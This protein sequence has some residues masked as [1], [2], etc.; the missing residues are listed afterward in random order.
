MLKR[1]LTIFPLFLIT[2]SLHAQQTIGLLQNSPGNL[3]GYILFTPN[4]SDTTYLIDKCGYRIHTWPSSHSPALSVYLMDDGSI[5][6]PGKTNN[7]TFNGGGQGGI[8][9]RI[10]WNGNVVWSYTISS[11]TECQHHD[12]FPMANGNI[13]VIAYDLKTPADLVGAGR[14][15]THIGTSLWSEKILELQPVGSSGANIV[16]QWNLWDHIVQSYNTGAP[17]YGIP[18]QHPDRKSTRL[19]SSHIPLSRM[20]SSA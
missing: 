3:E 13:L 12:I 20:P 6:R 2:G 5:L 16:W 14:D 11:T 4:T 18:S 17:N 1:L 9:E 8:I 10:D 7:P 19:N 15:T